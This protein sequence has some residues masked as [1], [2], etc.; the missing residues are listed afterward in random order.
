MPLVEKGLVMT[1]PTDPEDL[2]AEV[3]AKGD[4]KPSARP[5][6]L[7]RRSWFVVGVPVLGLA[8]GG[9]VLAFPGLAA[10]IG[11]SVGVITV[12]VSLMRRD[13]PSDG[14]PAE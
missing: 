5:G 7:R 8:A 12:A 10:P 3:R 13:G 6:S 9:L 4:A 11:T 2:H 14:G 1:V